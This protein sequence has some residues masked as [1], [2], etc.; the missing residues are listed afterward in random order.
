M[1]MRLAFRLLR[2]DL[3]RQAGVALAYAF[4]A[5][6]VLGF[7][8]ANGVVSIVWPP[9]GLALA[10]L[11]IGGR[12]YWPAVFVGALAGNV[13]AGSPFGVALFIA[14]GNTLEGL[15]GLWLVTLKTDFDTALTRP[16]DFWWLALAGAV[17]AMV[18]AVAGTSTLLVFGV[19]PPTAAAI[20]ALQWWQGD[21]LGMTLVTPVILVW[22]HMPEQWLKRRRALEMAAFA[23]LA[24]LCGQTDDWKPK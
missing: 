12:T 23:V 5:K 6:I 19:L 24:F 17:S 15:A 1:N 10:A 3:P 18:G 14:C 22:R 9:S 7:F 13:M 2:P 21:L 11:V 8:S 20:N 16:H 4:A